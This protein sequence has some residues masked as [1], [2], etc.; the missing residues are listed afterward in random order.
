MRIG[1]QQHQRAWFQTW[2]GLMGTEQSLKTSGVESDYSSR[3]T[4]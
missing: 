2:D 4:E 1:R 3:A